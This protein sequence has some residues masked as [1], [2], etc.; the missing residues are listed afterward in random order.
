MKQK[1]KSL[2][3][4]SI[5]LFVVF[6]TTIACDEDEPVVPQNSIVE[7][8]QSNPD[9]SSLVTALTKFPDLVSTLSGDG[10]F[11]V[12]APTNTAFAGLLTA[13]GQTSINDVPESVLKK[14][15]QYHVV[16]TAALKSNQLTAGNV[17]T[18]AGENVV[19]SLTGGV[20]IN[21]T[22]NVTTPDVLANNGVVHVIDA[23]LV[24]PTVLPIVGTIYAPAYFNKDFSTLVAAV[25]GASQATRDLLL[26]S[27]NKTLFAPTNAAFEAAGITALP[28]QATLD[29]ILAYHVIGSEIKAAGLPTNT[30]PSNSEVSTLGGKIYISNRGATGVFINGRTKVTKTDIEASN[31]VVHVIDYTLLPPSKT[32]AT[33]ATELSTGSPAQFT[34]LVAAL[35]RIPALLNAASG[36]SSNLTVF[37]PTDAAFQQLY[38]DLDVTG[39]SGIDDAT[40][41]AVLQHHIISSPTTATGRVFSR[42][43]VSADVATLNGN[44]TINATAGTVKGSL[45]SSTAANISSTA[46]LVNV[47]GSNGVIHTIDRVL[48]PQ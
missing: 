35:T 23:V 22:V 9:L 15:L 29:A 5:T 21:T 7:L 8:A 16:T 28:N 27:S 48:R 43:L 17:N 38:T 14:V 12:F 2:M 37:A 13:I 45:A 6:A 46:S 10:S 19:I 47:L 40:L 3:L 39:L 41:T 20:R 36:T 33:I 25:N 11:T 1:M 26:N 32:I 31:G 18:A 42:D 24:P 4:W 30:A 34:Q 44:I